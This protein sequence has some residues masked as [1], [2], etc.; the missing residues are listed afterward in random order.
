MNEVLSL[1]TYRWIN[2]LIWEGF[3]LVCFPEAMTEVHVFIE[4]L[5]FDEHEGGN[6]KGKKKINCLQNA[7]TAPSPCCVVLGVQ[8]RL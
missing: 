3:D 8:L 7:I 4:F 2:L 5:T 6:L 1:R